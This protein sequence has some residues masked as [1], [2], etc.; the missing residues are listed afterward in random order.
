MEQ[1]HK[2]AAV[3]VTGCGFPFEDM[4][5]LLIFSFSLLSNEAMRG[6]EIRHN[7]HTHTR[8]FDEKWGSGII[9]LEN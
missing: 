7:T 2:P 3:N 5:Y 1:E 9:L 8:E 4:N 6:V